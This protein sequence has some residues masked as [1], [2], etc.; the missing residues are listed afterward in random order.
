MAGKVFTI[1]HER[2]YDRGL[3]EQGETFYKLGRRGY[4]G[5][6]GPS[7]PGGYAFSSVADAARRIV[8]AGR[9]GEWAVYEL[10]ADW[11][12]D[13]EPSEDGWWNSLVNDARIV[14][15]AASVR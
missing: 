15:R 3:R 12:A 9:V 7:Y 1:G 2:N 13:T 6:W 4:A 11:E 8:E 14:R 5:H 10:A